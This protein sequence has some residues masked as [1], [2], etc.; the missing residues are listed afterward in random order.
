[1]LHHSGF[2]ILFSSSQSL[3][4]IADGAIMQPAHPSDNSP[5]RHI[6]SSV[7]STCRRHGV[8]PWSYLTA[9][10]QKL[11]ENPATNLQ[12]LLPY[13]RKRES[14]PVKEG[15]ITVAKDAPKVISA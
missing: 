14:S 1:L 13:N 8:E 5:D 3:S 15:E 10:I 4:A 12:E 7:I 11:T 9:V 6:V 2:E